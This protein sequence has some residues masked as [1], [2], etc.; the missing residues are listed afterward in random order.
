MKHKCGGVVVTG[1]PGIGKSCFCYYL[2]LRLLSQKLPVALQLP[3][4]F[5]VFHDNGVDIH[6]LDMA[7]PDNFPRGTWALSDSNEEV[8]QPC[9]TFLGADKQEMA[10]I[11]QTTCPFEERWKEWK[12]QCSADVFAMDHPSINEI[13]A[14]GTRSRHQGSPT[15][16]HS[17]GPSARTCVCLS[18]NPYDELSHE[19]T[20]INGAADFVKHFDTSARSFQ[21]DKGVPQPFFRPTKDASPIGRPILTAVVATKRIQAIPSYTAADTRASER[22]AF[23]TTLSEHS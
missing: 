23:Y 17:V 4:H 14:L 12:E 8:R 13:T 9:S 6:P 20:V 5:L 16:L 22:V 10:W 21:C 3:R 11:V 1:Q 2:V 18:R 7:N 19:E 15:L